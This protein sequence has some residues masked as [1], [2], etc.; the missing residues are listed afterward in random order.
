MYIGLHNS[1]FLEDLIDKEMLYADSLQMRSSKSPTSFSNGG[2]SWKGDVYSNLSICS[3][4]G[5][6]PAAANF[7]ASFCACLVKAIFRKPHPAGYRVTE[8]PKETP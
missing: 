6:S 4:P 1:F 5:S 8:Q 3:T 7:C 2:G